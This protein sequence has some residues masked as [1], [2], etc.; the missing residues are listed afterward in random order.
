MLPWFLK[1]QKTQGCEKM[2]IAR[3]RRQAE[4]SLNF[5]E[6]CHQFDVCLPEGER[7]RVFLYE[8]YDDEAAFQHHLKTQ[9][10]L[11]FS[12]DTADWVESK[13]VQAWQRL[14]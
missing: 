10:F 3:V 12:A 14:S 13:T 4:D 8:I 1:T 9:H 6:A 2:F 5:E 11:D 7:N